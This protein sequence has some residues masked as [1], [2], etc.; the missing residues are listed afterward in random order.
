MPN[1]LK[2]HLL[3]PE[4]F[5]KVQVSQLQRYH[6]EDPRIFYSGDDVW[7]VPLEVYGGEQIS[8]EPYHIT[9]Q[10]E[11]ITVQSF[12]CFNLLHLWQGQI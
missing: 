10:I 5:F 12:C 3:V 7:Q 1:I 4:D 8:V 11:E 2:A 9:A 6:V